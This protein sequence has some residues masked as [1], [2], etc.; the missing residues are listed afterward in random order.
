MPWFK[1]DDGL[2]G[3]A[4]WLATPPSARGLWCSAGSWSM[5][6]LS[7]GFIP[8]HVIPILGGSDTDV[9]AL[10]EVG[11]WDKHRTGFRF[12]DWDQYQPS[13]E[14]VMTK[15]EAEAQRKADWRAR[16][17]GKAATTGRSPADVPDV[18]RRDK[19]VS[20]ADVPDVS[21]PCPA[22]PDPTRPD[23]YISTPSSADEDPFEAWW[24]HYPR[25]VDKGHARTAYKR[26]AKK[27]DHAMLL[28]AVQSFAQSTEGSEARFIAHAATWL[29][30]ERWTD[31]SV[32]Q[33]EDPLVGWTPPP[34]PPELRRDQITAWN[35]EQREA[36]KR[37]RGVA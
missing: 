27:T 23:P 13:R 14:S 36:E 20:P 37:R 6:Q 22:L 29:N 15:R 2:W 21:Q 35:R 3:S 4:K 12:H 32:D 5:D 24:K 31:Q 18:S 25:K 26:A 34:P 17:S 11:L 30:G 19:S 16:K 8:V 10:I 33:S 9:A 7:D 28:A 1:V